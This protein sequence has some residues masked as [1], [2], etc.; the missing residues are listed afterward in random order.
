M[1]KDKKDD[2]TKLRLIKDKSMEV[3]LEILN[4]SD[5]DLK[6]KIATNVLEK[7]MKLTKEKEDPF[8]YLAM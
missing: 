4:G 8:Q 2:L 5:D 7:A 6:A 1:S 3:I